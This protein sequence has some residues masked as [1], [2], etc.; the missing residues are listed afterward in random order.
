MM[1]GI[2]ISALAG[3]FGIELLLRSWHHRS[4]VIAYDLHHYPYYRRPKNSRGKDIY[5]ASRLGK[6][7][8]TAINIFSEGIRSDIAKENRKIILALGCSVTEGA[9]LPEEK[10]YPGLLQKFV[11]EKEY[12]V[13]NAGMGG[14]GIFQIEAM[15]RDLIHYKPAAV[16]VQFIDFKRIPLNQE[17]IKK[18]RKILLFSQDLKKRSLLLW[19]LYKIVY[20]RSMSRIRSPYMIRGLSPEALWE[21][22]LPYLQSIHRLCS[23]K[24]I[25]LTFFVWPSKEPQWMDND[26]FQQKIKQFCR[27]QGINSFDGRETLHFYDEKE[28]HLPNDAHPSELANR[29]VAKEAYYCLKKQWITS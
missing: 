28:L 29:L 2:A 7:N 17:K 11:D 13:V 19:H 10:T 14:Y 21:K 22:N 12:A 15:L 27:Q 3:L 8:T 16:I 1:I 26:F 24:N 4:Q 18:T 23:S 9:S 5:Y 6:K 20:G 25:P